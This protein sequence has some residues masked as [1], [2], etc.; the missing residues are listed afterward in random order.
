[1]AG[2]RRHGDGRRLYSDRKIAHDLG[3]AK[4]RVQYL[5]HPRPG[6]P[7]ARPP[8]SKRPELIAR[9]A[10]YIRSAGFEALTM[11]KVRQHLADSGFSPVPSL[12]T[13][14]IVVRER[15]GLSYRVRKTINFRF[16]STA[17][18]E[19]RIWVTRLLVMFIRMNMLLVCVDESSF[20]AHNYRSRHWVPRTRFMRDH[21]RELYRPEQPPCH[22]DMALPTQNGGLL[23]PQR[24]LARLGDEHGDVQVQSPLIQRANSPYSAQSTPLASHMQ[25]LR[26]DDQRGDCSLVVESDSG[27]EQPKQPS[28]RNERHADGRAH[29]QPAARHRGPE[30]A[31]P[32]ELA[33][34]IRRL[35]LEM[36]QAH[37]NHMRKA[38]QHSSS[39]LCLVTAVS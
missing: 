36:V 19:K 23:H 3:I 2:L 22:D 14:G 21:Q 10:E 31:C 8:L 20:Q 5:R 27:S 6:K 39:T 1:M 32:R 7:R 35:P 15:L 37:R 11:G 12:A 38:V 28:N 29:S 9:V 25:R 16:L 30:A 4:H 17:F 24:P 13:I 26:L 18:D 33:E 34:E